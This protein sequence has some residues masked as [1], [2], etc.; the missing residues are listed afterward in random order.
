MRGGRAT[1]S[2]CAALV[3]L[4]CGDDDRPKPDR[5]QIRDV[6]KQFF[7][8]AADGDVEAVCAALTGVG[9]AQAAGRGQIIGQPPVPVTEE[10]CIARRAQTA[11]VTEDLPDV[12]DA[13]HIK[14]V[15]VHG[16]KATADICNGALCRPQVLRKQ[17]G[18]WKIESFQL[19]VN[20]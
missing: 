1:A 12:V 13:L 19:P 5:E 9:R 14:H 15:R 20:D 11:T 6:V 10:R 17:A 18:G 8:N 4:G 2:V 16:R 3:A 7:H